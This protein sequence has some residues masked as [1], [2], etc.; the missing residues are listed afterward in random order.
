MSAA[1]TISAISPADA[2]VTIRPF[3]END[4]D[5]ALAVE[6]AV[7]PDY[8]GTVEEW[9]FRDAHRDPKCQRERFVAET[10]TDNQKSVIGYASYDQHVDMYHPRK[11][12]L[13]VSVL[14]E[15]QGAGIGQR[16]YD[17]VVSSVQ[18]LDPLLLRVM[19]RE[20]KTRSV[21]FLTERKFVE[22]MRDW[23]SRLEMAAFDPTVFANAEAQVTDQNITVATL[24][25]VK[26][27]YP[28]WAQKLFDLDWTITLDMPAPDTLTSPTFEHWE[29]NTLGSPNLLPDAWFIA[30]DG[31]NFVGESTL[32]KESDSV[33]LNVGATGVRREYRRRGIAL[34]LKLRACAFAKSYGCKQIRT[35]N[36]QTNRA[37]LSINE[38]LGF[39][40]QPAWIAYAKTLATETADTENAE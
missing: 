8:P 10:M 29:K 11:F 21:R 33:N 23:E 35:W 12:H 13:N 30:L 32:W 3:T 7:W 28:D 25:E 20:D 2:V 6:M 24:A 9:R 15:W 16:L 38:S 1:S 17:Q 31:D 36:A 26:L 14:P 19:T 39:V 37:M 34:A 5:A 40:K 18:S 22:E 27:R 4:Y